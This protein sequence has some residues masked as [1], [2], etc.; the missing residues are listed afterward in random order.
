MTWIFVALGGYFFNAVSALLD[1]L[2]L[3]K[4]IPQP[5]TYAFYVSLFSLFTLVFIPF[6]FGFP[7]LWN[8]LA[9]F[10]SGI[11]FT[12]GLFALYSA[13]KDNEIS[14]ISP[15]V[16]TVVSVIALLSASLLPGVIAEAEMGSARLFALVLLIA[17]GLLIAF[18]L[19]LR[20]GERLPLM[21]LVA[22]T[23]LAISVLLLKVAYRETDFVSGLVWSRIGM[24]LGGLSLLVIPR[25][26]SQILV[27]SHAR[28]RRFL[29]S[30]AFI[31]LAN[32]SCA[33]ISAFLIS[34]ATFLG[35][36]SFVQALSG[37]QYV[38]LFL[39]AVPLTLRFPE[40]FGEK[41][42]FWDWFQKIMAIL[43]IALG[44]WLAASGGTS[45]NNL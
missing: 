20:K 10:A 24:F 40:I 33:G 26:R 27:R 3:K 7:G 5:A 19:P 29:W 17:G 42:F 13:V 2:L 15:L 22:G 34:Y 45:L 41:L 21:V 18:D 14:R 9:L 38:F 44:L 12:Y 25:F 16:G 37:T 35:P 39:L 23:C 28:K 1:K 43:L 8:T 30:T 36:V 6:G 31:F 11:L 4:R 32:K